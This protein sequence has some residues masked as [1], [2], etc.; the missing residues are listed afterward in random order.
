ML[1]VM[2]FPNYTSITHCVFSDPLHA[3]RRDGGGSVQADSG[4]SILVQGNVETT[5]DGEARGEDL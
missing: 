1:I 3:V 2:S 5:I 4:D